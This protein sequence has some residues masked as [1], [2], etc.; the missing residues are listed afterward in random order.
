MTLNKLIAV[1]GLLLAPLTT[2]FAR[3]IDLSTI[4]ARDTVQL[5]IYNSEDLTLVR[6]TR[7][8]TFKKGMNPLQF[9]WANTLIDPSSVD[10]RFRT[11]AGDLN[12][13]DT[14][15]PHDKPQMLY[16]NVESALD[17]DAVVEITYFTSGITWSADY[18]CV[19]N[20][21]ETNMSFDG[22][23][24]ISN[25]SGEDYDD[26]QVRLVVGKINLVER[27]AELALRGMISE[28]DADDFRSGK[29]RLR[30]MPVVPDRPPQIFN[31]LG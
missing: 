5:T 3:N 28:Q 4:P 21:D 22:F 6:E 8:I 20:G 11:H 14:A 16:W 24:R 7:R 13:L 26:A 17:G 23:V 31:G 15:F 19:S 27:V 10:L 12:L 25:N 1:A 2:T 9:S 29:K 30:Q 18:R